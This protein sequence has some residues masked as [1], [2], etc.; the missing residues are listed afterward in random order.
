M[1]KKCHKNSINKTLLKGNDWKKKI[2]FKNIKQQMKGY[3]LYII[4]LM[5]SFNAASQSIYNVV[6]SQEGNIVS[7][8]YDL[9]AESEDNSYAV[10]LFYSKDYEI[11]FGPLIKVSGDVGRNIIPGKN[12]VIKW[13]VMAETGE[14]QDYAS[15]KI[16][17][18]EELDIEMITVEG[19]SFQMGSNLGEDDI[20]PVHL[21]T[22]ENFQISK[23]EITN[24]QYCNFLN[25]I[26]ANKTGEYK[27]VQ[28][29]DINDPENQINY[30]DNGFIPK[31]LKENHPVVEVTWF[32]AEAFCQWAGGR[33]PSE[34]EW[35]YVARE[36]IYSSNP[37]KTN[38]IED[39]IWFYAN[40][41]NQSHEVGQKRPNRLGVYD[42][43]GNVWEWCSDWYDENYYN[44]SPANNP[45]G[46]EKGTVKCR[47]GGSWLN[48]INECKN[49]V[50]SPYFSNNSFEDTGFRLV[51]EFN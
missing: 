16:V 7:I 26:G 38:H 21:V 18:W 32:G 45:K 19:G 8:C 13:N 46:P 34:A 41:K 48:G 22:V 51:K 9:I 28:Y 10:S 5:G 25:N 23:F 35:E 30:D 49:Y 4:I 15:F 42:I 31:K 14:F 6:P 1:N 29:I 24:G 50:R 47:R 43:L 3:L 11:W 20:K 33:L 27:G 12:K 17:V 2:V 40:S 39:Y 37:T 36:G 44:V